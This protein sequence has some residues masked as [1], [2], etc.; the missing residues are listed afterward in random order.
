MIPVITAH[1]PAGTSTHTIIHFLQLMKSGKF[2][3]FDFGKRRNLK[4]YGSVQPPDYDLAKVTAK[5][6]LFYGPN[7]WLADPSVSLPHKVDQIQY[8]TYVSK[9][10]HCALLQDVLE[11]AAKL[12]NNALTYRVK[13]VTFNHLDFLYAIDIN[14][15]LYNDLLQY[16]K[17]L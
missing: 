8:F 9:L 2:R 14:K 10:R 15:L 7:D 4:M 12:P 11:L 17:K 13:S 1:N 3:Q 5:V 16:L 6:A